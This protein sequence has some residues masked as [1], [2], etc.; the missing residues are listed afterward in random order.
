MPRKFFIIDGHA[1]IYRAYYAPFGNL[2]AP[3]GEPTRATH[4]FFQML[5]NLLRDQ[6]PDYLLVVLDADESK[7][8]RKA[9]YPEYKAHR[10]PPP[11]DMPVQ[12]R[13]IV[14]TL[15]AAGVAMLSQV[16]YEAD[17]VI[18]TLAHR[19]AGPEL[20]IT[21]VS[22]D[23]DLEQLLNANVCMYDP[24]R[25]QVITPERLLELKGWPPEKA[26]EAQ[27]LIGDSVDNV[28][29]VPGIGPKT[30]AKLLAEYGSALGVVE[31]AQRLSPKQ[32][33]NVLAFAPYLERTRQLV[34]LRT[35]VPLLF[36]LE[37]AE[38]ARIRWRGARRV[39]E[40][41]G[42]RRLVEQL[43]QHPADDEEN[44]GASDDAPADNSAAAA[45]RTPRVSAHAQAAGL[46]AAL[47]DELPAAAAVDSA[48][49]A[50]TH[51]AAPQLFARD[52]AA[53]RAP[54][55]GDWRMVN[56]PADFEHF[57]NEL[58]KQPAFVIDTETTN[59]N[60]VDAELVGLAFSWKH[61]VGWYL[62]LRSLYGETLALERVRAEL[63]PLL[64]DERCTKIGHNLKYD[65]IV[66][67]QAG[68]PLLG[69]L[70]DT[71]I[72]AFVLDPGRSSFGLDPLAHAYFGH[73]MIPIADLIGRGR[74]TLRMDQ[75][76]LEQI[77]EYAAEDADYTWRLKLLFEPHLA[78]S[79]R[80]ALFSETEMPL[81]RVLAQMEQN[82]V[83]LDVELLNQ[84][85]DEMRARVAALAD[86]VFEAVGTVFNLDSPKQLGEILFDK[87]GFRVIRRTKTT[88]STDADTLEVLASETGHPALRLLL[89]HRELQKLLGTY[90]E[91]LPAARS[92]RSGRVHTSFHQTGA[93][94]GRLS[95]SEPNLQNIPV[96]TELGRQIRRAFI[97]RTREEQLIVADYSQ[98]EL[99][100]L[101]HF[102]Q[103]EALIRAFREDRDIH[104]VVAAEVNG[105]PLE[106]VTREMRSRAKAVNFGIIYGQTAFGLAQSTGMSR[107]EAQQFIDSYFRRYARIRGF[108]DRC[109]ADARRDGFVR[110]L[111]GRRRPIPNIH[112]ANRPARAQAERLSVNTVIQGSAADMIKTA[113]IAIHRRIEREQLPLR[114]LLQVHDELVFEAPRS[115]AAELAE[116]VA[117]QMRTALALNVPVKVDV[118]IAENWLEAK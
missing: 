46:H 61:A 104:A 23:K 113:M 1:Q 3:S 37:R 39:F 29:G 27:I 99:R 80:A 14:S 54:P 115:R 83:N 40:E 12:E 101:A 63:A 94:T 56:T 62:P 2:S 72:A 48:R 86:R 66:L 89:E 26:I 5:L 8:L 31:N 17:D 116:L 60:P 11:E 24:G 49:D 92:K 7:L 90:V 55:R 32:R 87:L 85:R 71:M 77:C 4:V 103:D 105:V 65:L 70:F 118:L 21:I 78:E 107:N 45:A 106:T 43:P 51:A 22:K 47:P 93:I 41:L 44:A 73:S 74:D 114:M 50:D 34:T 110:T 30:A 10:D 117:E 64:A 108:I 18:A 28:P 36:E 81:V 20:H 15:Q 68:M 109:I 88:R 82:G 91:A 35:D 98:I 57:V 33:D 59:V 6:Q 13:R 79:D 95:S 76:P 96:R 69:P 58:R 112:S 25:D 53:L 38:T 75:V 67:Q 102:C 111:L 42:F 19:L 84:L 97:P 16:G 9:I 100:V 52:A